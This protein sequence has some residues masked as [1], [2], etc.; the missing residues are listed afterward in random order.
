MPTK[1]PVR[2]NRSKK[3]P[4]K[5]TARSKRRP[6]PGG[7]R[8]SAGRDLHCADFVGRD[9]TIHYNFAPASL[10]QLIARL[11]EFLE[12]GAVFQLQGDRLAAE[13]NGDTLAFRPGAIGSLM[14]RRSPRAYW[15]GLIVD[16][17][18]SVWSTLFVPLK[19]TADVARVPLEIRLNYQ[20]YIPATGP[21]T[22]PRTET[23]ED[24]T[25]AVSKHQAFVI[26]G[27][28]GAGKTTTLRKLA[29]DHARAALANDSELPAPFFVRLS[30]QGEQNPYDFLSAQ[31]RQHTGGDLADALLEQRLLIL[32]DGLNELPRDPE[33]RRACLRAWREFIQ[34]DA[35]RNQFIF[36]S[37]ERGEYAGELD[38]PNVRVEPL[39]DDQI[40]EYVKRWKAEGLLSHLRDPIDKLGELAR[41]PFYLNLLVNAYHED[42]ALLA[43]RGRLLRQFARRLFE[44]E[45]RLA[46]KD[47]IETKVQ[48]QALASLAYAMQ[49]KGVSLS[50]PARTAATLMPA[51]VDVNDDEPVSVKPM[52]LFRLARAE[53]LLDSV[54]ENGVRFHH[55]LLQEYFAAE[56]LLVRFRVGEDLS[57]HWRG[58]RSVEEMPANAG[59][60]WNPLPGPPGTGWEESTIMACGLDEEPESLIEAVRAHDPNLAARCWLE[61]GVVWG[62]ARE[63]KYKTQ[64]QQDLLA[65]LYDPALHLRTRLQAGLTLG[66]LGDP[67]FVAQERAGV[68]FIAPTM[69]CVPAGTYIIGSSKGDPDSFP[70]E[71]SRQ[72]VALPTYAI[73]KWPVTNAEF[74]CFVDAGGY[75]DKQWWETDLAKS[76]LRGEDV[77]DGID[78]IHAVIAAQLHRYIDLMTMTKDERKQW[79]DTERARKS[80]ESPAFWDDRM[81]RNPSQPV[82][83]I[84][85]FEGLAYCAWLSSASGQHYR[86]PTELEW[87][88]AARGFDGRIYPWGPHWDVA[89][90]NTREGR[91]N[92]SS[93]V[94]AY[95]AAGGQGQF[96][97]EDQSGNVWE[98]TSSLRGFEFPYQVIY[99][100]AWTEDHRN[101][102]CARR[103]ESVPDLWSRDM[104]FRLVSTCCA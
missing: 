101:A 45:E 18:H 76:W 47:W 78:G 9:K 2:D 84:T 20:E 58:S 104:G 52:A 73:G 43:N 56:E 31:W 29:L 57:V 38:L 103:L 93:P 51:S 98:W 65:N 69:V 82:V 60:E 81:R 15:L 17:Q 48:S 79:F 34:D 80:R 63:E 6:A 87:E 68:C 89:R 102:R 95:A 71:F 70:E 41:N 3:A 96:G 13:L 25:A 33:I 67:R 30:Q 12:G 83:G 21:D 50:L 74:A 23:L 75:K 26:V 44:R 14:H 35:G 8:V 97:A 37:R 5:P 99:G 100:G 61:S 53:L 4:S 85:W 40:V 10:E 11:L 92:G 32:A 55:Q 54:L 88:V 59:N 72:N 66:W 1:K 24:I 22:P 19:A 77:T 62:A 16:P 90:A 86:L 27:D 42:A 91:V 46:R 28:P 94:G 7:G 64:L 49:A 39:D 36:T